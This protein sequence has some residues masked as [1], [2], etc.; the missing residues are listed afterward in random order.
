MP[1]APHAATMVK[2]GS[3]LV[4][5][6]GAKRLQT[7]SDPTSP[8]LNTTTPAPPVQLQGKAEQPNLAQLLLE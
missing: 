3:T 6:S 7:L 5:S 8:A 1:V 2:P 4:R